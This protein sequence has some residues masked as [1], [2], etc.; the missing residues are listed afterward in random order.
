MWGFDWTTVEKP[1][2]RHG[3][4]AGLL[5]GLLVSI[6]RPPNIE[7]VETDVEPVVKTERVVEVEEKIVEVPVKVQV[8]L[9]D[10]CK[11]YPV[12]LQ[13]VIDLSNNY[14][15]KADAFN[16]YLD[17]L[18]YRILLDNRARSK[19]NY[20]MEGQLYR[21]EAVIFELFKADEE[22][23]RALRLCVNEMQE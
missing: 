15:G 21:M 14:L 3:I 10:V 8:P 9:P 2:F 23:Q 16:Q 22:A 13:D 17:Y 1:T 11:E 4:F 19:A 7:Y 5:V 12:I 20:R 6:A 18:D